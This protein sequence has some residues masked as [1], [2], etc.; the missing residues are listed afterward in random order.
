MPVTR[1]QCDAMDLRFNFYLPSL[2]A[3]PPV[4]WY[5]IILLGD[6]GTCVLT[7][8]PGLHSTADREAGIRTRDLSIA[9][10]ASQPLGHRVTKKIDEI[11]V[12]H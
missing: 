3:S 9:S 4:G 5:Q 8:C 12:P 11:K 6:R 2:K 7:T 1:G 10:P